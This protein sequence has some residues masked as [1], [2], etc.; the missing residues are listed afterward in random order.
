MAL[1]HYKG[2]FETE[3]AGQYIFAT[4]SNWGSHLLIDDKEVVSWPGKHN[5]RAGIRGQKR[6]QIRLEPGVHKLEYHNCIS[7][8]G[9]FT[10]AAWQSPKGKLGLMTRGDFLPVGRYVVTAIGYNELTKDGGSFEWQIVDVW[11]L[12]NRPGAPALTKPVD[13]AALVQM[14][15]K[16]IRAKGTEKYSYRWKFDDGKIETGE[17]VEHV[18]LR[19]GMCPVTFEVLEDQKVVAEV[20][21]KV[22]AHALWDKVQHE[23]ENIQTFEKAISESDFGKVPIGALVN[24]YAFA[25]G[26]ERPQLKQQVVAALMKRVDELV[27]VSRHWRFCFELGRYLRTAPVQ[28]YEQALTL[29]TNLREKS[30][31]NRQVQQQ[32][33][34]A[35]AELLVQCFGKVQEAIEIL[36]QLEKNRD[37]DKEA[38][39]RFG[40]IWAEALIAVGQANRAREMLGPATPASIRPAFG[41]LLE[42]SKQ[43]N[44]AIKHMG[45]LR[46]ARLLAEA[47]DD[48]VQLDY[49]MEKIE[50]ILAEDPAKVLMPSL[51]LVRLDVHLARQEHLIA[52][53]LAERL[54][55]LEL[56]N[57]YHLEVLV[58]QVRAL[59][60]I[61]AVE[62]AKV[63][64][65]AIAKDYP[66]SPVVAEAKKAIVEVVMAGQER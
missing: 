2:F 52:F 66:Y 35:Q 64:Y 10:L 60:G 58:R 29:F 23:P 8:G 15:F 21:Q 31:E 28:Q 47:K 16:V 4:A 6:G 45:M 20:A 9:M 11:R 12:D 13:G 26:L 41:G 27:A 48:P 36:N 3:K 51:N 30:T 54:N 63:I 49:A 53:H 40:I 46:H 34:V 59:C 43:R 57:Y 14:R 62:Q 42:S 32:A 1:Y 22:Y 24:L 33:M 50:T 5:Y 17:N 61:K 38:T 19:T 56:S 55:K 7:W 37:L 25:D 44:R 18:F 65:A 39:R